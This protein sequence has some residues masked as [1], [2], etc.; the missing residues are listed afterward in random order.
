M[1]RR[2]RKRDLT[3][4]IRYWEL[5]SQGIGTIEACRLVGV[6]RKMGYRWRAEMGG[7]LTKNPPALSGRY[8]SLFERQ[9]I[10][11]WHDRG[12][13]I[14]EI[15]R[16]VGR[17]PST[18]SREIRR[19]SHDWDE[20]YEPVMAHLRA[21]ERAKRPKVGMIES[22]RWLT[23]EIQGKLAQH[24]SPEQIHLHLRRLHG[25]DPARTVC[26]E[27]IYQALYR[28]TE[29]GLSRSLTSKL[30]SGRSLRRRQRRIDR[31]SPRFAAAMRT[32]H[33]RGE[34]VLD[35]QQPGHWES[36]WFCQA[37]MGSGCSGSM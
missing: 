29:G 31:R 24:W 28:P 13:S 6:S 34:G 14:R 32:I 5:L 25:G 27:T 37:A 36:Q 30:R 1:A 19:D 4:E 7:M 21:S 2:G 9:R 17:S 3:R 33:Q 12:V 23:R 35:R 18:V 16:H 26:V 10:A 15:A 20:R 11:L 22:S 8:L